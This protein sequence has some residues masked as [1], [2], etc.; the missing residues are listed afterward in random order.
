MTLDELQ[1]YIEE[2]DSVH[3]DTKNGTISERERILLRTVKIMEE[4]GEL[5]DE[6]LGHLGHQREAKLDAREPGAMSDELADVV[7]TTFL[8][9]KALK[10]DIAKALEHKIEKIK[11]RTATYPF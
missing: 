9:A 3:R 8:L 1:Q 4:M 6:I 5:S 11:N 7:I 2:R 10:V